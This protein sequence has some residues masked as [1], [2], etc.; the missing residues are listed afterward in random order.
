LSNCPQV[1]LVLST[2]QRPG[3]LYRSLVSLAHQQ[4]VDERFEVVVADDGS[5]DDTEKMV[6]E[7]ARTAQFPLRFTTHEHRGFWLARSRNNGARISHG[8]Y[9]IFSDG[10]CLFPPD[11]IAQHLR[12]REPAVACSGDRV[13]MDEHS[14]SR[15]NP[16][17]IASGGYQSWIPWYER[18]RLAVRLMKDRIYEVLRHPAKPKLTGCNIGVWRHDFER[19]NGFDEHFRGW[20]CED[21]DLAQR[22]RASGVRIVSVLGRTKLYHMWHPTHL[23]APPKWRD[24]QNVAYFLRPNKPTRCTVGLTHHEETSAAAQRHAA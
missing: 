17:I 2:Y 16:A 13:R 24:G 21:D 3:H 18:R 22:L 6:S 20:G 5:T 11:F 15:L 8:S 4:G 14:T 7:F 1:S 12:L 10:D 19:I 23:T 9:L